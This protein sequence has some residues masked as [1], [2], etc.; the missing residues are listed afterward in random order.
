MDYPH[1]ILYMTIPMDFHVFQR[2]LL[3]LNH[4]LPT[5]QM[6]IQ[7]V[8][9]VY[10][11][12]MVQEVVT[13]FQ[14][15]HLQLSL[16]WKTLDESAITTPPPMSLKRYRTE[17]LPKGCTLFAF[18]QAKGPINATRRMRQVLRPRL[19][20]IQLSP[21]LPF[22]KYRATTKALL[23]VSSWPATNGKP[24]LLPRDYSF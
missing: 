15:G 18:N 8:I 23:S 22:Q 13:T 3:L 11:L 12:V 1:T 17:H 6:D 7:E 20:D 21:R 24:S 19:E 2:A 16:P 14:L 4:P 9:G 5:P 10:P